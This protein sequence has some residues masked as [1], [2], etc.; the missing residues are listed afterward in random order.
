MAKRRSV[1]EF[2]EAYREF[3]EQGKVNAYSALLDAYGVEG[4]L[5]KELIEQFKRD[6]EMILRSSLRLR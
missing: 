5:K 3:L 1:E 6:A 2:Q 4:E